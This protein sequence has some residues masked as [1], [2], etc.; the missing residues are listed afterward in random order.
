MT[1]TDLSPINCVYI[2]P[3]ADQLVM[4][5]SSSKRTFFWQKKKKK[6]SPLGKGW[7]ELKRAL[8]NKKRKRSSI[9]SLDKLSLKKSRRDKHSQKRFSLTTDKKAPISLKRLSLGNM[10]KESIQ[11]ASQQ[12]EEKDR[13]GLGELGEQIKRKFSQDHK[14]GLAAQPEATLKEETEGKV[15]KKK[16][17][18]VMKSIRPASSKAKAQ[19]P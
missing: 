19:E 13:G 15:P 16:L 9:P 1:K 17:S 4:G 8:P 10:R 5:G 2:F 18:E 14:K 11:S 6:K 12:R 3:P 7:D